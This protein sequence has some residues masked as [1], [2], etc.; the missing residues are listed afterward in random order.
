MN[1]INIHTSNLSRIIAKNINFKSVVKIIL[2]VS[3][4]EKYC[5]HQKNWMRDSWNALLWMRK[6]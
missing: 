1:N 2:K 4:R 5:T 6:R 3:Y